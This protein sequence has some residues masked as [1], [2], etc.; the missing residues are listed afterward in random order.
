MRK[1]GLLILLVLPFCIMSC[2]DK[3]EVEYTAAGDLGGQWI[4]VDSVTG[5]EFVLTTAN[6][7]SN[8]VGKLYI[9]DFNAGKAGFWAFQIK[10]D[11]NNAAMTFSKDST[12]NMVL[13]DEV[14][15]KKD[16]NGDKKNT[17]IVPYD[18]KINVKK[19]RI[20]K[21]AVLVP[22]G[23]KADK[24]YLEI[25]FEDDSPAYTKYKLQGYRKTGFH[26]DDGF[27][28]SW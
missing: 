22:S 19:G 27:V 23:I 25:E 1:L 8:E 26:E 10:V 12:I 21:N 2:Y 16:Y 15:D 4:V 7:T 11:A 24:I 13:Q 5:T 14:A 18:I 3:N 6:V 9:T 17:M 20:V 28:L